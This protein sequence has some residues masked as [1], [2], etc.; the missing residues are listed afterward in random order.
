MIVEVI[1]YVV[2]LAVNG[3]NKNVKFVTQV[4]RKRIEVEE[5]RSMIFFEGS[6]F[7][8]NEK[9]CKWVGADKVC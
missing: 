8:P 4:N 3:A 6:Y 2:A 1:S 9:T 7:D 5:K